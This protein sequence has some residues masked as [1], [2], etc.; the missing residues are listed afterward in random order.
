[1]AV[2]MTED[3]ATWMYSGDSRWDE[4][5]RFHLRLERD[6]NLVLRAYAQSPF[7]RAIVTA[8]TGTAGGDNLK[9]GLTRGVLTLQT[10]AFTMHNI[11]EGPSVPGSDNALLTASINEA[12]G[13]NTTWLPYGHPP[14][15]GSSLHL[16]ADGNLVL[17]R[18]DGVVTWSMGTLLSDLDRDNDPNANK[19]VNPKAL[20]LPIA[21]GVIASGVAESV[22]YNNGS[23]PIEAY[24]PLQKPVQVPPGGFVGVNRTGAAI[25]SGTLSLPSGAVD[26]QGD[27]QGPIIV[28]PQDKTFEP[29]SVVHVVE[30]QPRAYS[31]L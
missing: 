30:Q 19:I 24:T 18:P 5:G 16:Q 4:Q 10:M 2:I 1:M 17:Y 13:R 28:G 20:S 12:L 8:Q 31:W 3:S 25:P 22:I 29:G 26:D 11:W 23:L 27:G 6:G 7:R 21:N 15:T 9:L 14:A